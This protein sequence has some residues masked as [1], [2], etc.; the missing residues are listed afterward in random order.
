MET[1]AP[2]IRNVALGGAW[3]AAQRAEFDSVIS[4]L[5][6]LD[7]VRGLIL[8]TWSWDFL[9]GKSTASL[10]KSNGLLFQTVTILHLNYI[11]FPSFPLLATFVSGFS[12]LE[13]LSFN[14]VTWDAG[15]HSLTPMLGV[16]KDRKWPLRLLQLRTLEVCSCPVKPILYWLFGDGSDNMSRSSQL[17]AQV[18][19]LRSLSIPEVLPNEISLVGSVL[20]KLGS[21]LHHLE[22]GF[23]TRSH[24]EL[25][26]TELLG[27][28][29]L[30]QNRFLHKI[31]IH[32]LTLFQFPP[33]APLPLSALPISNDSTSSSNSSPY[34]WL[35]PFLSHVR[36]KIVE[37]AFSVWFSE[38]SHLEF[39]DWSA[40][41]GILIQPEFS[42]IRMLE[43]RVL[44]MGEGR[45]DVRAWLLRRLT[46]WPRAKDVLQ[47]TFVDQ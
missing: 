5:L 13:E 20:R 37:M 38:E 17:E 12:L 6:N 7:N 3:T 26:V 15:G 11:R 28:V 21:S 46:G 27:L 45:R 44:G 9:S 8:E 2:Y 23:L 4:L 33:R 19:A 34:S 10:L 22:I 42:G 36:S 47:V 24:D 32:Q 30:S 25:D 39:I 40:M 16:L 1:V 43:V 18:P 35:I 31:H 29:K 41:A 14:N